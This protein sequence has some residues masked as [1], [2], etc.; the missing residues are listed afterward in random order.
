MKI[1]VYFSDIIAPQEG[2][3]YEYIK[4]ILGELGERHTAHE[5]VPVVLQKKGGAQSYSWLSFF[6]LDPS[7]AIALFEPAFAPPLW[8]RVLYFIAR[9]TGA[10][11]WQTLIEERFGLLEKKLQ[12]QSRERGMRLLREQKIEVLYCSQPFENYHPDFPFIATIWDTGHF[13]LGGFPD[14]SV[15]GT[16]LS[17]ETYCRQVLPL[18]GKV[19]CES[20]Q[21]KKDLEHIYGLPS[22]KLVHAPMFSG[23]S[24]HKYKDDSAR[25][26][27]LTG[28]GLP[29]AGFLFYPAQFW[30]HKNHVNLLYALYAAKKQGVEVPLVLTGSDKGNLE[31]VKSV[32][33]ALE[34][35][36]QVHFAGFVEREEMYHLYRSA[37]ALVMPT[38]LGPTNIPVI[39][40]LTLGC[41]VVCSDF[42]G[43]REIAGEAALYVSPNEVSSIAS[44]L[45]ELVS[46]PALR[47][48][49]KTKALERAALQLNTPKTAADA[50][51]AAFDDY[52][53]IRRCWN[54]Y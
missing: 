45:V 34:L 44:A 22:G 20:E 5:F 50:V 28:K 48:E 21:G 54:H 17:R 10:G 6:G 16:F 3:G 8:L 12:Q 52:A 18:A 1:G 7:K 24:A 40:A 49:L 14:V 37:L 39:E 29:D 38:F 33:R 35:E 36:K 47:A 51:L 15:R 2:G 41:P 53:L 27:W 42:A 30:P 25:L 43:H 23:V 4:N 19:I 9:K 13:G 32:V 11:S 26:N 31:Y 46:R